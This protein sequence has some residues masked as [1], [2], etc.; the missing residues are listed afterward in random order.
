MFLTEKQMRNRNHFLWIFYT[1]YVIISASEQGDK[2][3]EYF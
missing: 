1:K 2:I 3:N